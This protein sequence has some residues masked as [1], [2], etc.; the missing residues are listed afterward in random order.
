MGTL[1]IAEAGVNHNGQP[2]LAFELIDK[3][4][5]AGAD[6]IKFQTFSAE[7]VVGKTA[8]K[9]AYQ[10]A[11]TGGGSQYEMLKKLELDH[12]AHR[13]LIDYCNKVGIEFMS[14][15]FDGDAADFLADQGMRRF[16]IPSGEITN[17]P[18]LE[19]I[20]QKDREMILSTGMATMD[21]VLEAV[22]VIEATR[23]A[24]GFAKPMRDVLS[25]LHCTSNYP[26]RVSDVNLRAMQTL[27]AET[28]LPVGYSDHTLGIAVC[29]AA[30]ALGAT[31]LEKHFTL[32]RTMEG[33]DHKASLEPD[34]LAALVG[35][36]RDIEQALGRSEKAPT[37]SENE[38][39]KLARRS[40]TAARD[41]APGYV[42]NETDLEILR[43]AAGIEPKH[44]GSL[45]GRVVSRPVA[46]GES[47]NWSDLEPEN[48]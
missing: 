42:L 11:A 22:A 44:F 19:Y 6:A 3:A 43:P 30:V 38:M 14:T 24:A 4:V 46:A 40:I 13:Q 10:Q 48:G 12:E 35:Q 25:I 34:E 15:P 31:V 7:K 45:T 1:I 28:G 5:A 32:D 27:G 47:L 8:A 17:H 23:K 29:S 36:V 21:E 26:T 41:L 16:K 18:F 37:A 2:G 33:P 20:A 39:R 9:A